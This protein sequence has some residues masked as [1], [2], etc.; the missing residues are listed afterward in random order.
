MSSQEALSS[1]VRVLHSF[2]SQQECLNLRLQS[3]SRHC[4]SW[5]YCK[6]AHWLRWAHVLLSTPA[7]MHMTKR[8]ATPAIPATPALVLRLLPDTAMA[9]PLTKLATPATPATLWRNQRHWQTYR[10]TCR[11]QPCNETRDTSYYYCDCAVQRA[12]RS[13]P[14]LFICS[15]QVAPAIMMTLT[16]FRALTKCSEL[17]YLVMTKAARSATLWCTAPISE[18]YWKRHLIHIWWI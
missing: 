7:A 18:R 14:F 4:G 8:K 5:W 2:W 6:H 13:T 11:C 16:K 17:P 3:F 9:M 10:D 1:F 12:T 15:L